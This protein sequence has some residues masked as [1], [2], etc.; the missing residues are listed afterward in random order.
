[1]K[2]IGAE[3]ATVSA[4][5]SGN[6]GMVLRQ[7]RPVPAAGVEVHTYVRCDWTRSSAFQS[8]FCLIQ[9]FKN[10]FFSNFLRAV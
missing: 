7:L 10:R 6:A 4:Q 8:L 2:K 9:T 5:T 3:G 1:M